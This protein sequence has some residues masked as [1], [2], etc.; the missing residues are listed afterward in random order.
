MVVGL[1]GI[2]CGGGGASGDGLAVVGRAGRAGGQDGAGP[3]ASGAAGVENVWV[4]A[5]DPAGAHACIRAGSGGRTA[6]D[7]DLRRE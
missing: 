7:Y 1:V 6:A 5:A 4:M 3:T 2:V